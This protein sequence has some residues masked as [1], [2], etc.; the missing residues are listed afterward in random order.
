[1]TYNAVLTDAEGYM[2]LAV[3]RK[4]DMIRR[5]AGVLT[6]GFCF[7]LRKFNVER[8][9]N[10]INQDIKIVLDSCSE[11]QLLPDIIISPD[12]VFQPLL[13]FAEPTFSV[14]TLISTTFYL[15]PDCFVFSLS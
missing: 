8:G 9:P 5:L 14:S 13:A 11:V 1:M 12:I 7:I 4:T 10:L 2:A 15:S 3:L 6:R